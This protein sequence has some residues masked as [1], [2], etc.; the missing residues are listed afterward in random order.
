VRRTSGGTTRHRI[1]PRPTPLIRR[2][3]SRRPPSLTRGISTPSTARP[4]RTGRHTS[5][6][7]PITLGG[8]F[9]WGR[10]RSRI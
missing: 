3:R 5:S 9:V 1:E 8:F 4:P 6:P 10:H 7:T 2:A